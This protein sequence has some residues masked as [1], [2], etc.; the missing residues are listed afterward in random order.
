MAI[1]RKV[2]T[3][4][5]NAPTVRIQV[6][7]VAARP[8]PRGTPAAPPR[9][10]P[11]VPAHRR[12]TE[13][14]VFAEQPT[15]VVPRV[16]AP[17]P[18]MP[19]AAPLAAAQPRPRQRVPAPF[20]HA[21]A[22]SPFAPPQAPPPFAAQF[23]PEHT[24][25]HPPAA[26]ALRAQQPYAQQPYAQQ[27]YAQQQPHAP[28]P[29]A[30][31]PHA[32]QPHPAQSA[33]FAQ[34]QSQPQPQP[35]LQPQP[36][37]R[38][39]EPAQL[40][41]AAPE[42]ADAA[43]V[44]DLVRRVALQRD[45]ASAVGVID[46]GIAELLAASAAVAIVATDGAI[47]SPRA[48]DLRA[49]AAVVQLDVV[50][51]IARGK[52]PALTHRALVIPCDASAPDGAAVALIAYRPPAAPA[53]EARDV[54][55]LAAIAN[56]TAAILRGFL[57][58]HANR[59]A[60]D[61][62]DRGGL[63][64]AEALKEARRGDKEGKPIFLSPSWLKWAYPTI[65]GLVVILFLAAALIQVPSYSSGSAIVKIDG[66]KV[67]CAAGGTV[68]TVE[69][70]PGQIVTKGD[71]LVK[72]HANS[73]E[74]DLDRV[75][76]EYRVALST[77]LFDPSDGA[78]RSALSTIASTRQR[79]LAAVD[80]RVIRATR[81]GIVNDVRVQQGELL[82]PGA[83]VLQIVDREAMPSIVAFLPG[84]DRPRLKP[85]MTLQLRLTGFARSQETAEITDVGTEVIGPT[86]ARKYLGETVGDT[87]PITTSVVIVHAKL[88]GRTFTA[89]DTSYDYHDG[90]TALGEVR[91]ESKSF[92]RTLVAK[93]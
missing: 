31:Q 38:G 10:A 65:L 42:A 27:P 44:L 17:L 83:P 79:A 45:L 14:V 30:Q 8:R 73:E 51:K 41:V 19:A 32:Q 54:M 22:P 48:A 57:V 61:A 49:A 77:F 53:F 46:L 75:D 11:P 29:Y 90:M 37:P 91:L 50:A 84:S 2:P 92:L 80:D 34:S 9:T 78:A 68:A 15:T 26:H 59:A 23:A 70:T 21:A 7:D 12:E 67:T 35:R 71:I 88:R 62:A 82:L 69:V 87:L 60:R 85:G 4:A 55:I 76:A 18:P 16:P 72:L 58:D 24:P 5:P 89:D 6:P 39:N 28:Q 3:A 1:P 63:F 56:Q 40:A 25:P 43:A 74:A 20:G 36:Q 52:D 64:R 13:V 93:E 47:S 33:L 66:E 81:D 86:A